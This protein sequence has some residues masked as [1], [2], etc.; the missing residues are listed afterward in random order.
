[1]MRGA[2]LFAPLLLCLAAAEGAH[3]QA[4]SR[5]PATDALAPLP[6]PPVPPKAPARKS[7]RTKPKPLQPAAVAPPLQP[8]DGAGGTPDPVDSASQAFSE[9]PSGSGATDGL[10]ALPDVPIK[11]AG[12]V[13]GIYRLVHPGPHGDPAFAAIEQVLRS[14]AE[15]APNVK[16]V[17]FMSQ[18]PKACDLEEDACFALLGAF[19]QLD[20]IEVGSISKADNGLALSVRLIDVQSGKRLTQA[21]QIV[22]S[23]DPLEI[24]SWAEA[25]GCKLLIPGGCKGSALIDLDL[26]EMQIVVDNAPLPRTRASPERIELPVGPHRVRV[27]VGQRTSLE[28]TLSVLR[29]APEGT[30]L[31][32]RQF[33]QGGLTLLTAGDAPTGRDG[34]PAVPASDRP[35]PAQRRWTRPSGVAAIGLGVAAAAFGVYEIQHARSLTRSANAAFDA[36]GG[37]Y[38][39]ADL[40]KLNSARSA[41]STGKVA[42]LLGAG[43]AAAGAVLYFAF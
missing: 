18:P 32:G 43:L 2:L 25:L 42:T 33:E 3:A 27:T 39:N 16:S 14:I 19:Q 28:R 38:R 29:D 26:P 4:G 40:D 5:D 8:L 21:Q 23:T 35:A 30:A 36:N 10:L 12:Y 7:R 31:Y 34:K 1:M 24:K 15:E 6:L 13:L 37:Y 20:L 11:P 17:T 9:A 41:N 22:A